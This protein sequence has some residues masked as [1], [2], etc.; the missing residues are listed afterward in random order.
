MA[1]VPQ[2]AITRILRLRDQLFDQVFVPRL[3]NSPLGDELDDLAAHVV[4]LLPR[5]TPDAVFETIRQLAG[6]ALT[7]D[8]CRGWAWLLAG[9]VPR[10]AAGRAVGPWQSQAEDEWLPFQI[11]DLEAA[12]KDR[13]RTAGANLQLRALAGS[14]AGLVLPQFWSVAKLK[15]VARRIGFSAP[16][17]DCPYKDFAQYMNLRFL[18]FAIA[19]KS[20]DMLWLEELVFPGYCLE[21]NRQLL[22]RRYKTPPCPFGYGDR[23]CHRCPVGTEQCLAATHRRTYVRRLCPRCNQEKYFDPNSASP[24]CVECTQWSQ[25]TLA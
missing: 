24:N 5:V 15:A 3:H 13:P 4:R 18:G 1:D 16:W 25:R 6:V 8:L 20:R 11:V 12:I 21:H 19:A 10:L 2:F 17:G 23:M 14:P 7:T 9:N 22:K